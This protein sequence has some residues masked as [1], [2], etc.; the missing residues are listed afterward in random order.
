MAV[1]LR[2]PKTTGGKD[3]R[4]VFRNESGQV[5]GVKSFDTMSEA[6]K[7]GRGN[8][9]AGALITIENKRTGKVTPLVANNLR[10]GNRYVRR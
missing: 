1:N 5:V 10:I 8:A 9:D 6:A 3:L 2:I 4:T 7:Y